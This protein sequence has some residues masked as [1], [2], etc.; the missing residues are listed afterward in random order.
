[1]AELCHVVLTFFLAGHF[2]WIMLW[3]LMSSNAVFWAPEAHQPKHALEAVS[4]SLSSSPEMDVN[5]GGSRRESWFNFSWHKLSRVCSPTLPQSSL[6]VLPFICFIPR[7]YRE[8]NTITS[9]K[10]SR[11]LIEPIEEWGNF[12][13]M[14]SLRDCAASLTRFKLEHKNARPKSYDLCSVFLGRP[15]KNS[16]RSKYERVLWA[17]RL[18][19]LKGLPSPRGA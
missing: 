7:P 9:E 17:E 10:P 6:F 16:I 18:G 5:A 15:K 13:L 4:G 14:P 3:I 11:F 12:H 1:M 8:R 19:D 2:A